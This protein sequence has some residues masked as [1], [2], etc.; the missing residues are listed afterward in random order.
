MEKHL[1]G[2]KKSKS[3]PFLATS[4]KGKYPVWIHM[5][6]LMA[7]SQAASIFLNIVSYLYHSIKPD[8]VISP[9]GEQ[10]FLI[11]NHSCGH[12]Y[13]HPVFL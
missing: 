11:V 12:I 13:G 4:T 5:R 3:T 9:W 6:A 2:P 1:Q 10:I 7:Y 8:M